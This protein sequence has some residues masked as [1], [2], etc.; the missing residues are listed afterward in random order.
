MPTVS[1]T[2]GRR[3]PTKTT[4]LK[5]LGPTAGN[6]VDTTSPFSA[7][8][9]HENVNHRSA[10]P[11]LSCP[12]ERTHG[13]GTVGTTAGAFSVVS[14][15]AGEKRDASCKRERDRGRERASEREREIQR[16]CA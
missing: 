8:F 16:E 7:H 5:P 3:A 11:A 15:V 12:H 1:P 14:E 9:P 2:V 13:A 4:G 6:A 10:Q